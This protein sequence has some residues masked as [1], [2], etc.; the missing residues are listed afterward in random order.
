MEIYF[1][2]V[3]IDYKYYRSL[4]NEYSLYT[5]TF[6]LG[7]TAANSFNL[8]LDKGANVTTPSVVTLKENENTI[9]TLL[10]DNCYENEDG[11]ITYELIDNMINFEFNYNA[12]NIIDLSSTGKV[13]LLEI[14]SDICTKAGV[15][16]GITELDQEEQVSWYDSTISARK[17]IRFIATLQS[18]FAYIDELGKLKFSK[19]K[20]TSS[21]TIDFQMLGDY[22]IGEKHKIT[23]VV[24]DNGLLV[25]EKGTTDG[26]TIYVDTDNPFITSQSQIDYIFSQI[27]NFEFYSFT[28]KKCPIDYSIKPGSIITF[29]NG[30][31]SYPTI[32]QYDIEFNGQWIGTMSLN[33]STKKQEETK[34]TN[35][36]DSA[37]KRLTISQERDNAQLKILSEKVGNNEKSITEFQLEIDQIKSE[38]SEVADVSVTADGVGT[39]TLENVAGNSEPIYVKIR[40]TT[41]SL[42]LLYPS[43]DLFPSDD[44]FPLERYLSFKNGDYEVTYRL[45]ADLWFLDTNTYDEFVLDYEKQ[46]CYV[47]HRTE[48]S[49][50]GILQA[51]EN[52]NIEYFDYPEISLTEGNYSVSLL[53][54]ETAS[55]Y[56]RLM[57]KSIYTEQFATKIELNSKITQ[58]ATSIN[59][60]VSK[61]VDKDKIVAQIN[62][63]SDTAKI[64]ASKINISGLI[65]AVNNN[66]TTTIDGSKISTGTITADKVTS[67]FI[68]TE[69]FNAQK[70]NADNITSGTINSSRL[71]SNVITT[72]NFSSQKIN[73]DNIT[74][75][76]LSADKISSGVLSTSG[77][78]IYNGTGFIRALYTGS[79]HPY[80]SALNVAT[81]GSIAGGISF[82][83]SSSRT[84]LGSEMASLAYST[85]EKRFLLESINQLSIYGK[86]TTFITSDGNMN[87]EGKQAVRYDSG[88]Y[89]KIVAGYA[90]QPSSYSGSMYLYAQESVNL[91]AKNGGV[92]AGSGVGS[93]NSKVKTTGGDVSSRNAKKNLKKFNK[94]YDTALQIL[95]EMNLYSYDYK[96]NLYQD[97]HQYGFIIDEIEKLDKDHK[98]FKIYN[99]KAIVNGKDLNFNLEGKRSKDKVVNLMRYD[100]DALDKYLLTVC[101]ALLNKV[102]SLE[103]VIKNG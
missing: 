46:K 7:S 6:F 22:K 34:V 95:N 15:E 59:L 3:L 44:L 63:T 35:D 29:V 91:N 86:S 94:E 9:A 62:L 67:N 68:T 52:E 98:F 41:K 64:E 54:H 92:Y 90:N 11:S 70:I 75:G 78:D 18:S 58:T 12:K 82:R 14:L 49:S 77:V 5:D 8:V 47:I 89:F 48:F 60:E 42:S 1:D 39:V 53:G 33:I 30:E 37:I 88:D 19:I 40:P 97:L 80:V 31:L 13:S 73:A 10:V 17:Y 55:I 36:T 57:A 96:Y 61:K 71:S 84:G 16:L 43:N 83:N 38:I 85:N 23:R 4:T 27:N 2:G 66:E 102:K 32:V 76:T 51:L 26:D 50:A 56:C 20:K 21:K 65:T 74:T 25:Y 99:E 93:S 103:G 24:Y 87:I 28:T 100:S 45:P 69:N 81:Q 79:A 72:E 101:K